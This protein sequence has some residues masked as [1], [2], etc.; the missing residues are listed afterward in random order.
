MQLPINKKQIPDKIKTKELFN[1]IKDSTKMS[2]QEL[3]EFK[4]SFRGTGLK[5]SVIDRHS[6]G[7]ME[8]NQVKK[9]FEQLAGQRKIGSDAKNRFRKKF[10]SLQPKEKPQPK[11]TSSGGGF[12]KSLFGRKNT[13]PSGRFN[14]MS[15]NN[16]LQ[17]TVVPTQS[18][19]K[20]TKDFQPPNLQTPP[21]TPTM[22]A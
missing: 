14:N 16:N 12:L 9:V 13:V 5:T 20:S 10:E 7:T 15:Q 17:N 2:E 19:Q 3:K 1:L 21:H 8:K 22:A 18:S 11:P 6:F 4:E